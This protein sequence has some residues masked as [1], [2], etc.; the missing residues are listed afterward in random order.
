MLTKLKGV[1]TA[2]AT[3]FSADREQIDLVSLKRLIDFQL[4]AKIDGLVIA[5]STGE[6]ACLTELEWCHL[7]EKVR[8]FSSGQCR[9]IAGISANSTLRAVEL[10]KRCERFGF[11]DGVMLVA[12][13]YNK[14]SQE[15]I[16]EHFK[17]ARQASDLPIIAYNVPGRTGVNVLPE[18]FSKLVEQGVIAGI[19]EASGNM[20]QFQRLMSLVRGKVSVFMGEDALS[21]LALTLGAQGIISVISNIAPSA[22][23]QLVNSYNSG[24]S[25]RS[26][27]IQEQYLDL[28]SILFSESNPVPLKAALK[29]L[30]IFESDIPRLPLLSARE[31]TCTKLSKSVSKLISKSR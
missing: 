6:A 9:L 19:K 4:E 28:I 18:T 1:F 14:P 5:G 26:R 24:D 23:M 3:P 22:W 2:I 11:L 10:I 25:A 13:F 31:E 8:E 17:A 27:E 7:I 21:Y 15:G 16:I 20:E 12:P 29:Q 30:A